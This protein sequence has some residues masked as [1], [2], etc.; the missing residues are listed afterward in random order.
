MRSL[1]RNIVRIALVVCVVTA[2][3]CDGPPTNRTPTNIVADM[4][5]SVTNETPDKRTIF[6][7]ADA[8]EYALGV[9]PARSSRSFPV[10]S[11]FEHSVSNLR[12]EARGS[13]HRGLRS[14]AFRLAPGDRFVWVLRPPGA[15]AAAA[16]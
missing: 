7:E 8:I 4:S 12:L 11:G 10:L 9:V 6:L 2:P 13:S 16:H 14:S 1:K 15:G 5:I 3:S